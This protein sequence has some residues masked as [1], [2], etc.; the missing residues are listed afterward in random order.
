VPLLFVVASAIL[1]YY[2]FTDNVVNSA[3]GIAVIL[4]GVPFF[5]G[6]ARKRSASNPASRA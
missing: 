4:A 1:L 3:V 5:Y 6:F 2:T